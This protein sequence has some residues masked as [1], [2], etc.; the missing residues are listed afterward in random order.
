MNGKT[1]RW[2][3]ELGTASSALIPAPYMTVAF[4]NTFKKSKRE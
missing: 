1:H 3:L 2:H 4:P